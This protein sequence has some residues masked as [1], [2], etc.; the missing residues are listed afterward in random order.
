LKGFGVGGVVGG[1]RGQAN[2]RDESDAKEFLHDA[3]FGLVS[4]NESQKKRLRQGKDR[5]VGVDL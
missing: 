1:E 4:A 5:I 3:S 2:R